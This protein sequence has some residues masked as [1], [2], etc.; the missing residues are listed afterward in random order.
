VSPEGSTHVDVSTCPTSSSCR[1]ARPGYPP[2]GRPTDAYPCPWAVHTWLDGRSWDAAPPDDER[3]AAR[4]LAQLVREL[5]SVDPAGAPRAGRRP[6]QDVDDVTWVRARG[7]A[8]AQAAAIVPYYR[9]TH[10]AFA[11]TGVRTVEQ[12]VADAS[13]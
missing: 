8:L 10:P 6:L 2:A 1:T 3:A 9:R 12:V 4:A 13:A 11:A 7:I 5:R